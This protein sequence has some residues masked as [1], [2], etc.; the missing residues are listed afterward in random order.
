MEKL[1]HSKLGIVSFLLAFIPIIYSFI[2]TIIDVLS[3]INTDFN[4]ALAISYFI[5]NFMFA[6][7]LV[8]FVLGIIGITLKGYK[9]SLAISAV[10]ISGLTLLVP[11]I[12]SIKSIIKILNM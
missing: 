9:K 1:K 12:S 2:Q 4:K 6:I 7:S 11:I 5:M 3:P 10:I 8:S